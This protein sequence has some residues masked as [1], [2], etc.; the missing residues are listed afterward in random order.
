MAKVFLKAGMKV[1]IADVRQDQLDRAMAHFGS[2][3]NLH[4]I[5]LDVTDREAMKRAADE[6]ERVF[7]K[8]H[9]I[10]DEGRPENV[11]AMSRPRVNIA[12]IRNVLAIREVAQQP[13]VRGRV[14]QRKKTR[15]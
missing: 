1:V 6:V 7:R 2:N 3:P 13:P 8:V 15:H 12:V 11:C 4:A 14:C 9:G 10:L 5:R